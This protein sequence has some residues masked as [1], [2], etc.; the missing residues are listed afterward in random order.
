LPL[1]VV[2]LTA[3]GLS[4]PGDAAAA[5]GALTA[6]RGALTCRAGNAN[7]AINASHFD[8]TMDVPCPALNFGARS[9]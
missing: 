5:A 2:A 7:K 4:A 6:L 9:H 3:V 1:A 8:R